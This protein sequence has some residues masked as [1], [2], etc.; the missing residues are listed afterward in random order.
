MMPFI[1]FGSYCLAIFDV[2][3]VTI[4][5]LIFL[6]AIIECHCYSSPSSSLA[7]SFPGAKP[8]RCRALLC[9]GGPWL[10]WAEH[11]SPLGCITL[12]HVVVKY[13]IIML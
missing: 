4:C 5:L 12:E 7:S 8:Q 11:E 13:S 6:V 3:V 2:A 10:P 9:L 1:T